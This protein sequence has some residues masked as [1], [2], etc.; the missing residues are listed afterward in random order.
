MPG[1]SSVSCGGSLQGCDAV[2]LSAEITS[3]RFWFLD[4][5]ELNTDPALVVAHDTASELAEHSLAAD[6]RAGLGAERGT[7][8]RDIED[9]AIDRYSVRE[10]KCRRLVGGAN[11]IVPALLSAV[12]F[13]FI[14]EPSHLRREFFALV[15]GRHE[16]HGEAPVEHTYDGA[17]YPP[18]VIEIGDDALADLDRDR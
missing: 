17:F 12:K 7:G 2:R 11:T 4:I 6:W 5:E 8:Q 3:Q 16:A 10:P 18:D 9:P 1:D 13:F 14:D 15:Q